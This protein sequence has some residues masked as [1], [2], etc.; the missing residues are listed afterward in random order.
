MDGE[1]T[2]KI[3]NIISLEIS[4]TELA[5][6]VR[7]PRLVKDIDWVDNFW[8]FGEGGKA[9]AVQDEEAE[10]VKQ[11]NGN[12]EAAPKSRAT[13]PKV[14]LYCLVSPIVF[15]QIKADGQM[16]A[17]GSWT[18]WHV[19]FAASSVY[20]SVHTGAKVGYLVR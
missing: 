16:G 13:W 10:R 8:N 2:H 7:P 17:K 11:E 4:G 9:Q 1:P 20:Y 14:Q 19:D 5:K 12:D 15:P 18:D 3:Y 6:R